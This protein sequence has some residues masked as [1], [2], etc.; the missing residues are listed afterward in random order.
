MP[1]T[2]EAHVANLKSRRNVTIEITNNTQSYCLTDPKIFLESGHCHSPP[3]PTVRPMKT[4]LCTFTK[5]AVKPEGAVGVLCYNVFRRGSSGPS[6]RI[7]IMFSV[8]YDM[9]AYKNWHGVGIYPL[10][11]ECDSALYKEMYYNK[12]Q[13]GFKRLEAS[14][15][16]LVFEGRTLDLM[17]TMSPMGRSMMKVE[18]WEK[19]FSAPMQQGP[20]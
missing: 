19:I 7:A 13:Q 3:Q 5:T 14:G 16:V 18:L 4:E 8:P 9:N 17:A 10:S 11:K 20:Y 1:E 6:E 2:A 12:E 15:S